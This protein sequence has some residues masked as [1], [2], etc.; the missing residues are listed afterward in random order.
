MTIGMNPRLRQLIDGE[1]L[2]GHFQE[3]RV[4]LEEVEPG[5]RDLAPGL[6]VDQVERLADLDVVLRLEVEIPRGA[7]LAEFD[8]QVFGRADR[9]VG[10]GEVGNP[11][12]PLA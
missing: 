10:V 1:L 8:A 12:E 5:A 6:E 4:V 11:A 2:K 3:D 7:D 9:G